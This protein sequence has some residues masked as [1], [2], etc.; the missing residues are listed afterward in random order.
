MSVTRPHCLMRQHLE[1]A[2]QVHLRRE[3]NSLSVYGL[4]HAVY[5]YAV[6]RKGEDLWKLMT[7]E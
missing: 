2:D 1:L 4:E 3:Q 6:L 5:H 7:R